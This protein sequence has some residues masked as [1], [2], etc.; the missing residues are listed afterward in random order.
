[1]SVEEYIRKVAIGERMRSKGI[2]IRS[3][4]MLGWLHSSNLRVEETIMR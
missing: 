3:K 4:E 2:S 1:M